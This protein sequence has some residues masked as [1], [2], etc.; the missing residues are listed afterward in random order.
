[1][2]RLRR[3]R[4]PAARMLILCLAAGGSALGVGDGLSAQEP[5]AAP[6]SFCFNGAP[7]S[8]C[9]TF[10]VVEVQGVLP[11]VQTS[12]RVHWYGGYTAEERSFGDR[13]QWEL[14]L[15]HNVGDRWAVGG[16]ARLGPGST[17]ALTGLTLR[18]RHWVE[19]NMGVDLAAGAGFHHLNTPG[20][21]GRSVGFVADG[22]LNFRDDA[23]VGLRLEQFGLEPWTEMEASDPGGTQRAVS[24]LLGAGSEW[25]VAGSAALGA[26]LLFLLATVDWS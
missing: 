15:M 12:R 7:R 23:Y 13:L 6:A 9:G 1:M 22:R 18:A 20:R 19:E 4:G 24:L 10:L 14:G 25:A 8:A 16:A 21:Y 5:D 17:G 26:A 11:I 2:T 3:D